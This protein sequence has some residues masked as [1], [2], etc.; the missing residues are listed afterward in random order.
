MKMKRNPNG[1]SV[2]LGCAAM[3]LALSG[4]GEDEK[5]AAAGGASQEPAAP[6]VHLAVADVLPADA[7]AVLYVPDPVGALDRVAQTPAG[8]WLASPMGQGAMTAGGGMLA[9]L[10]RREGDE[11][12]RARGERLSAF[13]AQESPLEGVWDDLRGS[14][15]E[16]LS[17]GAGLALTRVVVPEGRT[18][19]L[20]A[21]VAVGP[22]PK[23]AEFRRR[24]EAGV[25]DLLDSNPLVRSSKAREGRWTYERLADDDV[26]LCH[27][28]AG[29]LWIAASS[30][31]LMK[32]T[33]RRIGADGRMQG[34][35]SEH[36]AVAPLLGSGE[37][38]DLVAHLRVSA[39][40]GAAVPTL[41]LQVAGLVQAT[42]A[43]GVTDV[44]Y[45]ARAT[46]DGF[47]ETF[48]I[49][50]AA[51]RRGL[52]RLLE[53]E[54]IRADRVGWLPERLVSVCVTRLDGE[55]VWRVLR[56][57]ATACSPEGWRMAQSGMRTTE[58]T[59][60]VSIESDLMAAFD[61]E[62]TFLTLP[63]GEGVFPTAAALTLSPGNR[64]ALLV[65]RAVAFLEAQQMP[66]LRVAR[67]AEGADGTAPT[68]YT[69]G[70]N[71]AS[72][73]IP[74]GGGAAM[75]ESFGSSPQ[76]S[77]CV[78]RDR[79]YLAG[80]EALVAEA[81]AAEGAIEAGPV[82]PAA[83]RFLAELP[84]GT[85]SAGWQD[86]RGGAALA[87]RAMARTEPMLASAPAWLGMLGAGDAP[88]FHWSI[89]SDESGT[90]E[91]IVAPLP[92]GGIAAA[93]GTGAALAVTLGAG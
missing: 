75:Q 93:F 80:S 11:G 55:Q 24:L 85:F 56:E 67:S 88:P 50:A 12:A 44:V 36:G 17:G 26:T 81:L 65:E 38:P 29:D 57:F 47:H 18:A 33:L 35:W 39:C 68:I 70:L 31:E 40:L 5:T 42:G 51:P 92:F 3:L 74:G 58:A 90:I 79:C 48:R 78:R 15:E 19:Y 1:I 86:L 20:E 69:I 14:V 13:L 63:E 89:R 41:P 34:A 22:S 21:L 7:L 64:L 84:E 73:P 9:D 77:I 82:H 83:S 16:S 87:L 61:G 91:E 49:R 27:A 59:V 45:D 32:K 25:K 53:G 37:A 76:V 54:P 43:E 28:F 2:V 8:R 72:L 60:G 66:F 10:L 52:A 6:P 71:V 4:C 46:A 23:P 62:M 30:E